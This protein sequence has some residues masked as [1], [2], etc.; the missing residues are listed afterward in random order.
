LGSDGGSRSKSL[1]LPAIVIV[2]QEV[3]NEWF[4][5]V[6]TRQPDGRLTAHIKY[7][8]WS[9]TAKKKTKEL[10][11]TFDEP[12]YAFIHNTDH[13]KFLQSVGFEQT[14][15]LVTCVHPGKEKELFGEVRYIKGGVDKYILDSYK[16][17]GAFV[18]PFEAI[19]GL[20]NIEKIEQDILSKQQADYETNHYFSAGV[21]TRETKIKKD[22]VLTGYRHKQETVSILASGVISVI[23]VDEQGYATD[24]GV[25]Q[26]PMTF[27][28]KPGMKKIGFAHEDTVFLN[29]FCIAALPKDYHSIDHI[30]VVED[31]IFDKEDV[32]CLVLS[33]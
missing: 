6:F 3:S 9:P 27:V 24:F 14:G 10:M 26:S 18:L 30:E 33:Q 1:T 25:L 21:Y 32:P 22:C 5:A 23:A 8:K 2:E 29:S 7:H 12:L 13:W 19:D 15:R 28:T 17:I 20:G 11:D 16:E 4:D 31:F